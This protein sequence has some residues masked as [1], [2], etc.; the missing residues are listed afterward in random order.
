MG[1]FRKNRLG[2]ALGGVCSMWLLLL[3]K[4]ASVSPSAESPP[5][6]R[7]DYKPSFAVLGSK[8]R[9]QIHQ[10]FLT[11]TGACSD[12]GVNTAAAM[13]DTSDFGWSVLICSNDDERSEGL[14]HNLSIEVM[15]STYT[16]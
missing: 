3:L 15:E 14:I 8:C 9:Q 13:G 7:Y 4:G 10:P 12:N 2:I 1:I 11:C 16:F 6:L 5:A